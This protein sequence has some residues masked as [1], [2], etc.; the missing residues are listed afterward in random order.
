MLSNSILR[1]FIIRFMLFGFSLVG[2][3]KYL[4][5]ATNKKHETV[6]EAA[7]DMVP[8][9]AKVETLKFARENPQIIQAIQPELDTKTIEEGLNNMIVQY[10]NADSNN[11][12][13][14]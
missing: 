13:S 8:M 10:E 3:V 9:E 5:S 7:N 11:K 12:P 6:I 1:T 2:L 14:Q 4:D